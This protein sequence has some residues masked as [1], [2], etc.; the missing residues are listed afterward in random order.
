MNANSLP[1]PTLDTWKPQAS[2]VIPLSRGVA[3]R[4][5]AV[6]SSPT[7]RKTVSGATRCDYQSSISNG[8]MVTGVKSIDGKRYEFDKNGKCLNP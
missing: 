3:G 6:P 7:S 2:A 4:S 5:L 8:E 1:R